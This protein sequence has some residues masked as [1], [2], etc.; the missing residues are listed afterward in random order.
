MKNKQT[1]YEVTIKFSHAFRKSFR[2]ACKLIYGGQMF[3]KYQGSQKFTDKVVASPCESDHAE[4][5][6]KRQ[7]QYHLIG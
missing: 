5:L 6:E 1:I 7:Q 2:S 4:S 3:E